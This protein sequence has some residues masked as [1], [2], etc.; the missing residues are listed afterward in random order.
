MILTIFLMMIGS[1]FNSE[2]M[3]CF[4]H[5][6]LSFIFPDFMPKNTSQQGLFVENTEYKNT[7]NSMYLLTND[8]LKLSGAYIGITTVELN[9]PDLIFV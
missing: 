1:N 3:L 6:S 7:T 8:K 9:L 4:C 5:F 2:L